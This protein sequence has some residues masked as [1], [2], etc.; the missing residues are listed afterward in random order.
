VFRN[1]S[2]ANH[3][4]NWSATFTADVAGSI[5]FDSPLPSGTW[6]LAGTSTWTRGSRTHQVTVTTNPALHFNASCTVVPRFDAGT[7]TAVVTRNG[8]V[9]TVT[10]QFTACG[11][12][13]VTRS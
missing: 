3:T 4:R 6:N 9:S 1:G 10:V 5:T 7:L 8:T 2:T 13:T 11:Q 12:Y